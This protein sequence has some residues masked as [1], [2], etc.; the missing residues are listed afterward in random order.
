VGPIKPVGNR[1]KTEKALNESEMRFRRLFETMSEGV[2]LIAPDGK[3][4]LANPSA[5]HILGLELSAIQERNYI[6]PAWE[7]LRP[8]GTPM[9]PEEMAGPRAMS[10]RRS[11]NNVV[12]GVRRPDAA[13]SWINVSAVPI[14]SD[15]NKFEGV[16]GVFTDITDKRAAEEQRETLIVELKHAISQVKKLSGLLP[17]CASCKKIRNDKGYWNEIEIYVREHSEADFTHGLCPGCAEKL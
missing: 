11:V 1:K 9:P 14:I 10:E 5:V 7:I 12:M 15:S 6:V 13:I 4:I 16:V 8:D 2:I 3:I 17:I